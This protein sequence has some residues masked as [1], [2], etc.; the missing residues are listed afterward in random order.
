MPTVERGAVS[1]VVIPLYIFLEPLMPYRKRTQSPQPRRQ[2]AWGGRSRQEILAGYPP[3]QTHPLVV[4]D[5]LIELFNKQ[6]TALAKSVSFKT[7][8]QRALFLRRFFRELPAVAGLRLP[9]DPRRLGERHV[10]CMVQHWQ[11]QGLSI[12]TVQTYLSFLRGLCGWVGKHG[13]VRSPKVYGFTGPGRIEAAQ[14][15]KSWS[16]QDIDIEAKIK[17]VEQMDHRIGVALRL[18][19][20]FG[21]R[22]KEAI[23]LRPHRDVVVFENTGLPVASK[24]AQTCVHIQQGSKG[25]RPRLIPICTPLQQ[26][27][28]EEARALALTPGATVTDPAK[29]LKANLRRFYY[30]VG[31]AG[32]TRK[33][34]HV[35][36][37]GLRHEVMHDLYEEVSGVPAPVRGGHCEDRELD[38]Q[39]RMVVA[40]TAGHSRCK[41]ASAYLGQISSGRRPRRAHG[42]SQTSASRADKSDA[43]LSDPQPTLN[44]PE[45]SP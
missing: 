42:S 1:E 43:P 35:T 12:G 28:L 5:V 38:Q 3:G 40:L 13:M 14:R 30:V 26:A 6:H 9:P 21:L 2:Q 4:L 15:D 7:R 23:M 11:A 45:H 33:E 31:K 18:A 44:S 27:V 8:E 37:H 22:V 19:A 20:A 32:I 16:A 36:A 41:A 10:R 39:A 17:E 29:D 34:L 25:G 24:S